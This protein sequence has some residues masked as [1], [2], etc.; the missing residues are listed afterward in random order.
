M[1]TALHRVRLARSESIPHGA[2]HR[3]QLDLASAIQ[4][5]QQS[6]AEHVA[7]RAVG[8][9]PLPGFTQLPRQLPAAQ[10]RMICDE[11]P[12]EEDLF[13]GNVPAPIAMCSH[14]IRSV[15]E[16]VTERKL[17][18]HQLTL[19]HTGAASMSGLPAASNTCA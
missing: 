3:R 4:H 6:A 15:P 8:L 12:D 9:L 5:Q 16:S 13:A 10:L 2:P 18:M 17:K 11:L 14:L 1:T 19:R 7:Q